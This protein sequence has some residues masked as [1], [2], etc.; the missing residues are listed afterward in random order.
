MKTNTNQKEK[1]E[2]K[3]ENLTIEDQNEYITLLEKL[4]VF[5][6][7][8]I[9]Q[10]VAHILGLSYLLK[11]VNDNPGQLNKKL[12]YIKQSAMQLDNR[13]RELSVQI[14]KKILRLKKQEEARTIKKPIIR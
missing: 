2:R 6:S 7:H 8:N 11:S 5:I 13:T 3:N 4:M 12:M 10:P 9:R 14:Y 1:I